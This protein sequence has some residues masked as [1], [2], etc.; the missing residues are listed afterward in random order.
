MQEVMLFYSLYAFVSLNWTHDEC[1]IG[2]LNVY[3][4]L[5]RPTICVCLGR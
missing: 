1:V 4:N 5:C 2:F 3:K